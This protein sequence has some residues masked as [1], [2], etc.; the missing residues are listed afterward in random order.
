MIMITL[1]ALFN[2]KFLTNKSNNIVINTREL[3]TVL[4]LSF[5]STGFKKKKKKNQGNFLLR[6][7]FLTIK[8]LYIKEKPLPSQVLRLLYDVI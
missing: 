1:L 2:L 6:S 8:I 5:P 7:D 4:N 3:S